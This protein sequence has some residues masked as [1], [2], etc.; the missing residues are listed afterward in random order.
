[1]SIQNAQIAD[2]ATA[3]APTGGTAITLATDGPSINGMVNSY[4]TNDASLKTRRS[5][6]FSRKAP[7][8]NRSSAGGYTQAYR[9]T[10]LKFPRT[11]AD[12]TLTYDQLTVEYRTD[13]SA[14]DA[15]MKN[16]R[17]LG[18]QVLTD[19]DFDAFWQQLNTN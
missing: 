6:S 9:K 3:I 5:V 13:I 18:A 4:V 15:E 10:A 1:M 19:S 12:G 14:T 8:V 7:K 17:Y 2:N 16:Q 11:L